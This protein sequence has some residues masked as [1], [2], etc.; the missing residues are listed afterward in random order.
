M[1]TFTAFLNH[2]A[3]PKT[4]FFWAPACKWL[5]VLAGIADIQRPPE[6]ISTAQSSALAATGVIWARYSTQIIPVNYNLLSV[7]VFV[8]LTGVYQLSR[9]MWYQW[10]QNEKNKKDGVPTSLPVDNN[11]NK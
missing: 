2:P 10:N 8:A 5:I 1:S 9:K 11:N 4:I 6:R 3:G 7:N